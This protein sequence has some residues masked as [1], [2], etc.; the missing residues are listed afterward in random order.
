MKMN[1]VEKRQK[2]FQ[3]LQLENN[4][5]TDNQL[6]AQTEV[7]EMINTKLDRLEEEGALLLESNA[8]K[9]EDIDSLKRTLNS[10]R[11]QIDGHTSLMESLDNLHNLNKNN[12]ESGLEQTLQ[13]ILKINHENKELIRN[14]EKKERE[15]KSYDDNRE[16]NFREDLVLVLQKQISSLQANFEEMKQKI[17]N[18][19]NSRETGSSNILNMQ[20][21]GMKYTFSKLSH[22]DLES[23]VQSFEECR[24]KLNNLEAKFENVKDVTGISNGELGNK[25]IKII[26]QLNSLMI[27]VATLEEKTRQID[28]A[29]GDMNGKLSNLESADVF[30]QEADRMIIEKMSR[31]D[32]DTIEEDLKSYVD[33]NV[34]RLTKR[35]NEQWTDVRDEMRDKQNNVPEAKYQTSEKQSGQHKTRGVDIVQTN[36]LQSED[37]SL[38]S[39]AG[40]GD[41]QKLWSALLELYAAFSKF[42][43]L[44]VDIRDD[45]VQGRALCW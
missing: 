18:N 16:R 7:M 5:H 34:L 9:E 33:E 3:S 28:L 19:Y 1:E 36:L 35:V 31:I 40:N 25:M 26:E 10:I 21:E 39:P 13:T 2:I 44:L 43:E 8:D 32:K 29:C 24:D 23:L 37:K 12:N 45:S 22:P 30:L 6:V 20:G 4:K 42:S 38:E 27:K 11:E 41:S 14:I 15:P 17:F